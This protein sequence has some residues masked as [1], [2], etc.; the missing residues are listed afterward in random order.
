[1]GSSVNDKVRIG[2]I[3]TGRIGFIH[4]ESLSFR[5]PEADLLCVSD[6]NLNAAKNCAKEFKVDDI[7]E[8]Y[9]YCGG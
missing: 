6:I 4:A 8:D 2:L 9:C 7:Y 3:G 5:L 1:M